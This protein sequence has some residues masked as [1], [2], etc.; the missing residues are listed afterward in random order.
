L[1][2][3]VIDAL[4]FRLFVV[5]IVVVVVAVIPI[6]IV[7]VIAILVLLSDTFDR[8]KKHYQFAWKV[9]AEV[10]GRSCS[11]QCISNIEE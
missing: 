5:A 10:L 2:A 6:V 8:H 4:Y 7:I 11:V 3:T 9:D 1:T